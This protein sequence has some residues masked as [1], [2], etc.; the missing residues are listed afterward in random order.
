MSCAM[1]ADAAAH[2][3]AMDA[4]AAHLK[5]REAWLCNITV[6]CDAPLPLVAASASRAYPL[7]VLHA[8]V[9]LEYTRAPFDGPHAAAATLRLRRGS[10]AVPIEATNTAAVKAGMVW[11]VGKD[12]VDADLTSAVTTMK[13]AAAEGVAARAV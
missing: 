8:V 7:H 10:G 4:Y 11:P 1:R 3:A 13:T 2:A 6:G 12:G 9:D 5:P